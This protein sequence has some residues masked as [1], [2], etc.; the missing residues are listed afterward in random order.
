MGLVSSWGRGR[1]FEEP[2]EPQKME[3]AGVTAPWG[4][5]LQGAR[6]A[7]LSQMGALLCPGKELARE[8]GVGPPGTGAWPAGGGAAV[9]SR[10]SFQSPGAGLLMRD[11]PPPTSQVQIPK[12]F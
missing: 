12:I 7:V 8:A 11:P 2:P 4:V 6:G 10:A 1:G 9:E 5:W 3:P